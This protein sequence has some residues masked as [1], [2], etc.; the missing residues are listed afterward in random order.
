MEQVKTFPPIALGIMFKD[1]EGNLERT[2]D[3]VAKVVTTIFA[4]DTGSDDESLFVLRRW[5]KEQL[6]KLYVIKKKW[7]DFSTNR[8]YLLDLMR[9]HTDE[10]RYCILLDANDMLMDGDAFFDKIKEIDDQKL[11][12]TA[13]SITQVWRIE[14][15]ESKFLGVRIV[16]NDSKFRY[17]GK[18][19]EVLCDENGEQNGDKI[20]FLE[21]GF[22]FQDRN[23]GCE[24]TTERLPK[25]VL[26]LLD[27]IKQH[28][29]PRDITYLA[30]TY[31][32]LKDYDNAEIWLKKRIELGNVSFEEEFLNLHIILANIY[33]I[34][35]K[36]NLAKKWYLK[37]ISIRPTAESYNRIFELECCIAVEFA[38]KS[39]DLGD[40]KASV[41]PM[42]LAEYTHIR[43]RNK[44]LGE[45][46]LTV[47]GRS[48]N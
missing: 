7:V 3:S 14:N 28:N 25:D 17:T 36:L 31:A 16:R 41:L 46:L 44:K 43:H 35:K 29:R 6:V 39:C 26:V 15:R 8:N 45:E 11:E 37:A 5:C 48:K 34:Q 18:I 38:R 2:L 23:V 1:E 47:I 20:S 4:E 21:K 10:W 32:D 40:P 13:F 19:H 24:S 22:I 9:E 12:T 42:D 30:K 27:E 33:F